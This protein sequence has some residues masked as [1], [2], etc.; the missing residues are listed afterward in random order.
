VQGIEASRQAMIEAMSKLA[1]DSLEAYRR[2]NASLSEID[3]SG[4]DR[5]NASAKRSSG[6]VVNNTVNNISQAA[7]AAQTTVVKTPVY[8]D[9]K[10]LTEV[11]TK[12]QSQQARAAGR[13]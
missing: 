12:I 3:S 4:A 13:A 10:V 2:G 7:V 11:V 5:F 1:D 8:L 9:G 6:S